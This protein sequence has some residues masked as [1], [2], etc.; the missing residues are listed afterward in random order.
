M[1]KTLKLLLASVITVAATAASAQNVDNW[2]N[3]TGT[4]WK[5]GE[6]DPKA[7]ERLITQQIQEK[8]PSG[9]IDYVAA[10]DA[11]TLQPVSATTELVVY[12]RTGAP[13]EHIGFGTF[14]P[15]AKDAGVQFLASH[16]LRPDEQPEG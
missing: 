15:Q 2:V 13:H 10:A 12:P 9:R 6:R 5:N 3:S 1:N 14:A 11:T 7:L 8:A 4:S 16:L